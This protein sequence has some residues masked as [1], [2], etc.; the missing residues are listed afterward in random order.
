MSAMLN[1]DEIDALRAAAERGDVEAQFKLGRHYGNPYWDWLDC[2]E[3]LKWYRKAAMQGHV[4]AQYALGTAYASAWDGHKNITKSE[5][6]WVRAANQGCYRAQKELAEGYRDNCYGLSRNLKKA[7]KYAKLARINKD[8]Y[9]SEEKLTALVESIR[10]AM[11]IEVHCAAAE[12]GDVEEMFRLAKCYR[13]GCG[14]KRN[15]KAAA[16]W[17]RLAAER[18]HA[19][20]QHDFACYYCPT[21]SKEASEWYHKAAENGSSA[22]QRTLARDYRDGLHG[23][24]RDLAKALHYAE[25]EA[26][27]AEGNQKINVNALIDTIKKLVMSNE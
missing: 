25:M 1:K 13:T 7:L 20:A 15:A 17:Y 21:G 22:A 5:H 26:A 16:K 18:G 23:H 9:H 8:K 2:E 27:T 11:D 10:F 12:G 6:W 4:E 19:E 3:A 14:I 24:P